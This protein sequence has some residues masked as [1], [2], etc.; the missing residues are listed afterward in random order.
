[1]KKLN[2]YQP[3]DRRTI[4][5]WCRHYYNVNPVIN[6]WIDAIVQSVYSNFKL[7]GVSK[8]ELGI[9][10]KAIFEEKLVDGEL[11]FKHVD[12]MRNVVKEFNIIGE[13][14]TYHVMGDELEDSDFIIQNPDYVEITKTLD[15]ENIVS[16]TPDEQLRNIVFSKRKEDMILKKSI[17]KEI[18]KYVKQDKSIPLSPNFV[19]VIQRLNSPY[20]LRGT[21]QLVK[22]FATLIHDDEVRESLYKNSM[23]L[24]KEDVLGSIW[25]LLKSDSQSEAFIRSLYHQREQLEDWITKN[26]L[27]IHQKLNPAFKTKASLPT[28]VWNKEISKK[29][30]EFLWSK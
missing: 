4:N 19:T 15:G 22:Y 13:A 10:N 23:I 27:K 14:V 5:A 24:K 17:D 9:Y 18:I 29:D 6:T 26:V 1:M 20:D 8:R 30:F 25:Y 28:I 2:I 12:F 7:T 16:L 3:Q 11:I 21:S